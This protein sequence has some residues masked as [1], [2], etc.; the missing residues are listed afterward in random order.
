MKTFN[1]LEM[2]SRFLK[3]HGCDGLVNQK[4]GCGCDVDDLGPC[5]DGFGSDCKAAYT[6]PCQS[7]TG[8]ACALG[9]DHCKVHYHPQGF[10][11]MGGSTRISRN[12]M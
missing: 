7:T 12:E 3:E 9:F 4:I 1:G 8:G 10:M 11:R 2:V 5:G 6:T